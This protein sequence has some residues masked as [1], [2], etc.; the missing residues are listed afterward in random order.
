MENYLRL[1]LPFHGINKLPNIIHH[2]TTGTCR[3]PE[4]LTPHNV[5]TQCFIAPNIHGWTFLCC[6]SIFHVYI[7][8]RIKF[9]TF[10]INFWIFSFYFRSLH[11]LLYHCQHIFSDM[12]GKLFKSFPVLPLP[13]PSSSFRL[14]INVPSENFTFIANSL[15]GKFIQNAGRAGGA[16][17]AKSKRKH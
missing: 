1:L 4:G 17:W 10:F 3:K 12:A 13:R 15:R 2:L 6:N 16:K 9:T 11:K 14:K 7:N 8:N 5:K